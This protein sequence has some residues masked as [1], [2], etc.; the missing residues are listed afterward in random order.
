MKK[1]Y[2]LQ[3]LIIIILLSINNIKTYASTTEDKVNISKDESTPNVEKDDISYSAHIQTIGDTKSYNNNEICGTTGKALQMEGISISLK[4]NSLYMKGNI[5]YSVH[6]RNIG[7]MSYKKNGE[8]AGTKGR[9]LQVEAIK[10]Y[11]DG[12]ISQFYDIYYRVHVQGLGWLDWTKNNNIAGT[13]G[14]ALRV[15]AVQIKLVKKNNEVLSGRSYVTVYSNNDLKFNSH[16]QNIGNTHFVSNGSITGTTGRGLRIE[17]L[18]VKLNSNI[19]KLKGNITTNVKVIGSGWKTSIN[20]Y[21]GTTGQAKPIEQIKLTLSGELAKYYDIYYRV[22][23]QNFGWLGWA[24]NG[25][26][27]GTNGYNYRIEAVQIKLVLKRFSNI[28][29]SNYFKQ[30]VAPKP[31]LASKPVE[32]IAKIINSVGNTLQLPELP[33][34]CESVALTITLKAYGF[35]LAKTE[36]ADYYLP[37][38]DDFVVGF[39]GNP[40]S[41][42]GLGCWPAAIVTA[43]NNY[44]TSHN[45]SLRGINITG[46]NFKD[47]YDYVDKGIPVIV[48]ASS[49]MRRPYQ[50]SIYCYH[51]GVKT[52]WI[53]KEHC[54][55]LYG[56]NK[57]TNAVYISDPLEGKVTRDANEFE[58]IYNKMGKK[59]V[60]VN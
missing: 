24:K 33:T 52:Y 18:T 14:L 49:Y 50:S 36:I 27:A 38:S 15:E 39:R 3:I 34:G 60:L 41:N 16:V 53:T 59:A 21:A 4:S 11:L 44:L 58:N 54:V 7:W 40:R 55:V 2:L 30:Y 8:F 6:V 37:Y 35:N 5:N 17:G 48:W 23:C 1:K 51:N 25:Q 32:N 29:N 10:I 42:S 47:L 56:Y 43:A 26:V 57:L 45:S 22:H 20:S 28:N 19:N 12:T 31:T 13:S 9:K 46:T